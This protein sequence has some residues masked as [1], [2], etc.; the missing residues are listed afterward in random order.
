[1]GT[2]SGYT[3]LESGLSGSSNNTLTLPTTA[4]DTVAALGTAETW[5]AAQTFTNA[6]L[7]LKGSTSGA[8]TLEA[9]AIASSYIMTFPAATDTVDVLGTAQSITAA[10]TFS[11][12]DIL[13][14]G[15]STGATTFFSA[16]ASATAYTL[17]F[18]AATDTV[19]TLAATQTLTGKS[20]AASEVN[21]GTLAAAQMPAF[22]GDVT[23]TVGTVA[24]TVGK[25]NGAAVPASAN[26]LASNSSSQLVSASL[27]Q[28]D[29]LSGGASNALNQIAPSSTSGE[30]LI[31]NGSFSQPGYSTSLA[32]VTSVNSTTIPASQTLLYSGGAL[33][34][35]SSGTVTNLTGTA[36]GLT[37][38]SALKPERTVTTSPTVLSSDMGG[39][40]I[41]NVSGGG[42]LTIPA[43]SSSV[44]AANM[45]LSIVN[46]SA[47]TMAISTTPTVNSGGGCVT[48]TGIP[49]GDSWKLLSNGTTIDCNQT[50]SSSTGGGGGVTIGNAVSGGTASTLLYTN[51]SGNVANS[52]SIPFGILT[53]PVVLTASSNNFTP[54]LASSNQFTLTLASGD[55]IV[56]PTGSVAGQ[57][58]TLAIAQPSSGGPFTV[59]W[60]S[61]YAWVAGSAPSLA[62]AASAVTLVSCDVVTTTP[63]M[64][65]Y[66][67][68][69]SAF[70]ATTSA[71][72][73][74]APANT[75]TFFAQGLSNGV[76]RITP[77]TTGNV[78]ITITG[79]IGQGTGTDTAA[80][81]G[82]SYYIMY[83]SGN[84]P[85]NAGALGTTCG[86]TQ[87][88]EN[89]TTVTTA[90]DLFKPFSISC[91]ASLTVGTAYYI[92]LAAESVSVISGQKLTNVSIS[93]N[94]VR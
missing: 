60:G 73:P 91:N 63:T 20:I 3:L 86:N 57:A 58:F 11:N 35:P 15:S 50:V 89:A 68:V 85:A 17:T 88:Y 36:T 71:Q 40:I 90:A 4:T 69:N 54:T 61:G 46:Y 34:T 64:Q 27:T 2:S 78:S 5:T 49:T 19:V 7:L 47:S 94:E 1:M 31:S 62:T 12:S 92:D 32:G 72:S 14:L 87:T 38:G 13:L 93:A 59:A 22:T 29:L 43:I 75:S 70:L 82:I 52:A 77:T 26:L 67:P 79:T 28:Y 74:T 39:Q 6:D 37:A 21:S 76:T 42:T 84:G 24:T 44:L 8:M 9:P 25:V 18:P 80:G 66:G 41:A 48:A 33:G 23:S 16:N 83:G 65:C 45:S 51:S 10:K 81:T 56:N 30:A 55:T 53:T